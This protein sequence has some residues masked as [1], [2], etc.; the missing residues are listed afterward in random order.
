MNDST[1]ATIVRI[2]LAIC[3]SFSITLM[4]YVN[5]VEKD[6]KIIT[7]PNGPEGRPL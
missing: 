3:I 5:I 7:S 4:Y 2:I 6:Y 1:K